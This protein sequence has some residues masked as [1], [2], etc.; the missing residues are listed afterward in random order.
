[1]METIKTEVIRE[2]ARI[3]KERADRRLQEYYHTE[4]TSEDEERDIARQQQI[5]QDMDALVVM[6][7]VFS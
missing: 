1:M 7:N 3:R 5:I 4:E 6:L 2:W